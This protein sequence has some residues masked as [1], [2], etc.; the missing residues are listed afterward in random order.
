MGKLQ[1]AGFS[2]I[3]LLVVIAII[4]ILAALLLPALSQAR[5][6]AFRVVC[7]SNLRQLQIGWSLYANDHK[8]LL[9][10]N[11]TLG[12][13]RT[14]ARSPTNSWVT[15]NAQA[16]AE[17]VDLMSGSI[18]RYTP[19]PGVFHCPS[20]RSKLY[21]ASETR[22][23]SYS[24]DAS[25]SGIRSD[26]VRSFTAIRPG[27]ARV[28]TFLDEH[29]ESIDDGYYLLYRAPDKTWPNLVADRHTQGANLAFA[30]GHCEHWKWRATKRFTS[31]GQ[32]VVGSQDLQ[33]LQRLQDR[34]P[35]AP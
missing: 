30:D 18:Y 8:D 16:S 25:L 29:E 15:G 23:R 1:K 3:E 31:W 32:P 24:L 21:G 17:P 34:L 5:E 26:S 10:E 7:L 35:N 11:K 22:I 6:M 14:T 9:P 19:N 20:D 2:L 33:D 4:A 27:P 12:A 13:G 28:F